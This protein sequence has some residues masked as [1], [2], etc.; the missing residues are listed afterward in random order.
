MCAFLCG[1]HMKHSLYII[2]IYDSLIK[3]EYDLLTP[4][5][6]QVLLS[7]LVKTHLKKKEKRMEIFLIYSI[8]QYPYFSAFKYKMY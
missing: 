5:H 3:I 4:L 8:F 1:L 2:S 7:N 6:K